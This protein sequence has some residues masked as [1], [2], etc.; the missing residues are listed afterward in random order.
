MGLLND[1]KAADKAEVK[2]TEGTVV[3]SNKAER[4]A[5]AK[6]RKAAKAE[7]LKRVLDY[8][9]AHEVKEL[10]KDVE[11]LTTKAVSAGG[12]APGL[13]P[14]VLFGEVKVGAKV[15][16]IDVFTK[17]K[18]GYPEM[19]KYIKKWAEKGYLIKY[20]NKYIKRKMINNNS[21]Y[22]VEIVTNVEV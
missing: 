20:N 8:L 12:F 17:H 16:A 22:C 10:A 3:N 7:A 9:K 5:R 18:K 4:K 15:S 6:E 19:R 2:G 13:T 21:P 1:V 14:E 11:L